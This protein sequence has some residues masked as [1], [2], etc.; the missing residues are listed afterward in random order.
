MKHS[1]Q[2]VLLRAPDEDPSQLVDAPPEQLLLR[3]LNYQLARKGSEPTVWGSRSAVENFSRD[4]TDGVAMLG[5][6]RSLAPDSTPAWRSD[7]AEPCEFVWSVCSA[8]Q[9][10]ASRPAGDNLLLSSH[11]N[12]PAA[13]IIACG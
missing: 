4:V 12:I 7:N 11:D 10:D 1:P 9:R 13:A 3:W 2:L 6:L 5:L 8:L